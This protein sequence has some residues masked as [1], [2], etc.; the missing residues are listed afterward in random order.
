MILGSHCIW[1]II[2]LFLFCRLR[3]IKPLIL[4][5]VLILYSISLIP[6][7][8][9][10]RCLDLYGIRLSHSLNYGFVIRN[11]HHCCNENDN[12]SLSFHS[13]FCYRYLYLNRLDEVQA[14]HR[15]F[16][17]LICYP[18]MESLD[19]SI[20]FCLSLFS[21]QFRMQIRIPASSFQIIS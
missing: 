15:Y 20:L 21:C 16:Q 2:I 9:G 5:F 6:Y 17:Y 8:F 3:F 4:N 13:F 19:L 14:F 11:S 10:S 1:F 12:H 18:V 7:I